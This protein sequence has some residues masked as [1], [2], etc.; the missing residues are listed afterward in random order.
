MGENVNQVIVE[1]VCDTPNMFTEFTRDL[2]LVKGA[3]W[4]PN[5]ESESENSA[6]S[7]L[8]P[9]VR[10]FRR[11]GSPGSC[12]SR[13][14]SSPAA[15]RP[16]ARCWSPLQQCRPGWDPR[17]PV[18][19]A[20]CPRSE[21]GGRRLRTE[22][23][24]SDVSNRRADNAAELTKKKSALRSIML[25]NYDFNSWFRVQPTVYFQGQT[26]TARLPRLLYWFVH[27]QNVTTE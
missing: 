18:A 1:Y 14:R 12:C 5:I 16:T 21:P 24:K 17:W 25:Y 8:H 6:P 26:F 22:D 27:F 4:G 15:W 7:L 23:I 2:V 3:G 20:G 19:S 11:A 9:S 13:W 10:G